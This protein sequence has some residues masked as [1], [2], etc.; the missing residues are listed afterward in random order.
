MGTSDR[1]EIAI[2]EFAISYSEQV[3]RDFEV[4]ELAAKKGLIAVE[5]ITK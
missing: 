5:S 4:F 1:F 3:K 2:G